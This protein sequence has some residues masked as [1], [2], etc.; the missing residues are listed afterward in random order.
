MSGNLLGWQVS[1]T[2]DPLP[3]ALRPFLDLAAL[4]R[5]NGFAAAPDQTMGF[6]EATGLLG[7]KSLADI[8]RAAIALFAVSPER[9]GEF[10]A[11]FDAIFLGTTL[12]GAAPGDEDEVEAHE[13]SGV[14]TEMPEAEPTD[15]PG[16][17]ATVAERLSQ[18]LLAEDP[19]AALARFR[20]LAPTRLPRRRSYRYAPHGG[21]V[22]D[23]R[24]T[25]RD[26]AR[27]GGEV[28]HLRTRH[29]KE[30]Q[31]RMILLIDISGSMQDRTE[32]TLNFAHTL[33]R[34]A[35][36]VEIFTLGTR[37]TR[38]TPALRARQRARALERAS[39]LIADIDGGTR[40]GDALSAFLNVP[41]YAGF[42]RGASII[43]L[44]DGLERGPPA[45][46]TDA[47]RRL[48]RLAWRIDWMNP[49]ADGDV[50][51]HT[52]A[53]ADILP[54]LDALADGSSISAITQ[55]VLN[56]AR[57]ERSAA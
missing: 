42:A 50:V 51:P 49:L 19:D 13:P 20:R 17:E 43:V 36:R 46:L 52:G 14:Q 16:T 2:H 32:Q 4:L 3:R 53:L 23:M 12:P 31:R 5:A 44:S 22:L 21:R 47:V 29:R 39:A 40:I 24:R 10:D 6:I 26:A 7:P 54:D 38:I 35:E 28:V 15:D 11:L 33:A 55:H 45:A 34:V 30:R 56:L 9:R 41:R 8:R 27:Q 37:L 18:R 25:L 48:A 57:G 1:P